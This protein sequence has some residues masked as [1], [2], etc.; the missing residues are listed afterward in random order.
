VSTEAAAARRLTALARLISTA[1]TET[2]PRL[3]TVLTVAYGLA[4]TSPAHYSINDA[5]DELPADLRWVLDDDE[6][7][8]DMAA[9]G[10]TGIPDSPACLAVLVGETGLN[11][12]AWDIT[13]AYGADQYLQGLA[14]ERR[15]TQ[16][17]AIAMQ[18]AEALAS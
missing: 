8:D 9:A 7:G 14:A 15:A 1:R 17:A 10:T 18:E 3:D 5:R 2:G 6:D 4:A 12:T 11:T 13:L 16:A